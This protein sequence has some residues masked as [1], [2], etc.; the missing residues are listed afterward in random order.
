M[1]VVLLLTFLAFLSC[2][3]V[4]AEPLADDSP[5]PGDDRVVTRIVVPSPEKP[6]GEVQVIRRGDLLV[7][8]TLL[9]SRILK[10]VVAVIDQKE[11]RRWP[12]SRQGHLDSRRYREELFRATTEI[13]HRFRQRSDQ[14]EKRQYLVIE[15]ILGPK[16]SMI[17]LSLPQVVG[18][19]GQLQLIDK[20]ELAVW[21][22]SEQYVANNIR[23]I[24]QDSFDLDAAATEKLLASDWPIWQ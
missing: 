19:Y 1:R 10:K 24:I 12:E 17:A 8:Q 20:S 6:H 18:E 7:V 22:S 9:A 14:N 4:T 15:F 2:S 3:E 23:E 13:W 16:Q 11:Q 5:D 21:R